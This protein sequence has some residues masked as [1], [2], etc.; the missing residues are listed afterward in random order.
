MTGSPRSLKILKLLERLQCSKMWVPSQE[1]TRSGSELQST[2]TK[3]VWISKVVSWVSGVFK[4][5]LGLG[6]GCGARW[7]WHFV[8]CCTAIGLWT[9]LVWSL[10]FDVAIAVMC[11]VTLA[12]ALQ[13]CWA[14]NLGWSAIFWM[15]WASQTAKWANNA[16]DDVN[17]RPQWRHPSIGVWVGQRK[18]F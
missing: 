2:L 14:M 6:D 13:S 1:G 18:L 11:V 16:L 9:R 17:D 3:P 12:T 10:L 7:D 5:M 4:V 8:S 15:C